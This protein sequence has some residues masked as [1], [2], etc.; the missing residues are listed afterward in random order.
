MEISQNGYYMFIDHTF[1]GHVSDLKSEEYNKSTYL[2][3]GIQ[4]WYS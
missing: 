3:I 4:K 2:A 1:N